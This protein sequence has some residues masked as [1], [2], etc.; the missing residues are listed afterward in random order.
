MGVVPVERLKTADDGDEEEGDCLGVRRR[1]DMR[2]GCG[3]LLLLVAAVGRAWVG[4][5]S[6]GVDMRMVRQIH[7]NARDHF[8][9]VVTV[10]E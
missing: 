8:V 6:Q 5:V 4:S 3:V 9:V 2:R 10:P 1:S 7:P